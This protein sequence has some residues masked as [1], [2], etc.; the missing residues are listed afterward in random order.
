MLACAAAPSLAL[1]L[2]ASLSISQGFES[3][4]YLL[5]SSGAYLLGLCEGNYCKGGSEGKEPGNGRII[6]SQYKEWRWVGCLRVLPVEP[7]ENN[8]KP[9]GWRLRSLNRKLFPQGLT[10]CTRKPAVQQVEPSGS[11]QVTRGPLLV[12]AVTRMAAAACGSRSRL[13]MCR[14]APT[15]PTTLTWCVRM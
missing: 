13:S 1:T 11:K 8:V 3:I 10:S 6:I 12:C 5:T 2:I 4:V 9:G 14:R 7:V 15:L